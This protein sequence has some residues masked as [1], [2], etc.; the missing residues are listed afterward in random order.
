MKSLEK[1][2]DKLQKI[3]DA[4]RMDTL[5]PA[6][7]QA[8]DI[9]QEAQ[10]EA[11]RILKEATLQVEKLQETARRHIDQERKTF[12]SSLEQAAKQALERLRQEIDT[13]LFNPGLEELLA[14]QTAEPKIIAKLIE[15][16]VS[17]LEKEGLAADLI[18]II[19]K[20][21][22][23]K[24]VVAELGE[25][26]LQKLKN[27]T[28]ELGPFEGGAKVRLENKKMTLDISDAALKELLSYVRKDFRELIFHA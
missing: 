6:K 12:Q 8:Q 13:R 9:I 2:H 23:A 25:K 22:P 3:C 7:K 18:A 21:V 11:D 20:A 4:L 26:T 14:K 15:A 16:L 1:G 28:V 24:A 27:R 17:A 10:S 5:E 19:P